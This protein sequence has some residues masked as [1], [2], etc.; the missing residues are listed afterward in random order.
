MAPNAII[1]G[2]GIAS[3]Y[4][5]YQL[6]KRHGQD[7]RILI[8]EKEDRVGGRVKTAPFAGHEVLE[9][10]GIGRWSKDLLLRGLLAELG[11]P[12][13]RQRTP[14]VPVEDALIR[15]ALKALG[16]Y[17]GPKATFKVVATEVLGPAGYDAFVRATGFSDYEAADFHD[18]MEH[19][20]FDDTIGGRDVFY[21][22][23]TRLLE[24]LV[25]AIGTD[26]RLNTPVTRIEPGTGEVHIGNSQ[27]VKTA[28]GG[29]IIV[30]VTVGAL[31]RLFPQYPLY[32]TAVESQP[33][34]RIYARFAPASI[35]AMAQAVPSKRVVDSP[36]QKMIPID[37]AAGLYMVGYADNASA[38]A[39]RRL[40]ARKV[41][42]LVREALQ[43]PDLEVAEIHTTFW[44]EGTH[45]YPP[46]K[47]FRDSRPLIRALQRPW[48]AENV[49]VIGEAVAS[50]NQ[51]WVEGALDS[52]D[53]LTWG[54]SRAKPLCGWPS[55]P[56]SPH[57]G[58]ID[59]SAC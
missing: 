43:I 35:E 9:G 37:P 40:G 6:R 20:G 8:L 1:V 38:M 56:H 15:E 2:A 21:V 10:A 55:L 48:P 17:R 33:F 41:E 3:L 49:F 13:K 26:I 39:I 29:L 59:R 52:F 18:A 16:A 14:R 47:G 12:V 30:G 46:M 51:G 54:I 5:A 7:Y 57:Q 34:T 42:R 28:P 44:K 58:E 25:T 27:V 50:M 22:P 11:I 32:Q 4:A 36:L 19:Y 45:Y 31:R 24:A 23:W 53:K